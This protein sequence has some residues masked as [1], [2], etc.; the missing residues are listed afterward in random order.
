MNNVYIVEIVYGYDDR[1]IE[2]SQI[3]KV[4]LDA[5]KAQARVLE[6]KNLIDREELEIN[7][8]KALYVSYVIKPLE[9]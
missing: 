4:Y 9:V 6:L 3:D 7:G 2:I 1:S 8:Q 5:Y